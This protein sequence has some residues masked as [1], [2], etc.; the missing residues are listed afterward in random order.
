L[1]TLILIDPCRANDL[2]RQEELLE[3]TIKGRKFKLETLI[4]RQPGDTR[5]PVALVT[6]GSPGDQGDKRTRRVASLEPQVRDFAHRGWFAVGIMRR[7]F[8]LSDGEAAETRGCTGIDY[9]PSLTAQADDLEAVLK[10]I[11]SRPNTDM[12]RIVAVGASTG[13]VAVTELGAQSTLR[14]SAIVNVSGGIGSGNI[15]F[16]PGASSCPSAEA[17]LVW[18]FA[19]LGSKSRAP[20]LWLYSENDLYFRPSL[21]KRM[22]AAYTGAGGSAEL[23]SFPPVGKDGHQIFG[24]FE[25]RGLWLPRL[26][27]FLRA[28]NLPTWVE[29]NF[30]GLLARSRPQARAIL[31]NYLKSGPSEKALDGA[32]WRD[33]RREM[34]GRPPNRGRGAREG[35]G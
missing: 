28:H 33:G 1:A 26:D 30:A 9:R 2:I 35:V 6:H 34:V 32:Y 5:L 21:V 24:T 4:V 11:S 14:L 31:V 16:D 22:H 29:G 17:E 20:T 15:P 3:V 23:I 18:N 12:T 7:G 19:R 8:G 27:A 13:G 25:G 10:A